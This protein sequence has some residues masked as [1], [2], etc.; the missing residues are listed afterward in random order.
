MKGVLGLAGQHVAGL[1]MSEDLL[2]SEYA[3][4]SKPASQNEG[5]TWHP[6]PALQICS[7]LPLSQN[8]HCTVLLKKAGIM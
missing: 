4:A 7:P 5:F 1:S 2:K 6:V 8:H 3:A